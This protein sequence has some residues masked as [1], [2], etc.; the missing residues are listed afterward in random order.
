[1]ANTSSIASSCA[2]LRTHLNAPGFA[3]SKFLAQ[4]FSA[5]CRADQLTILALV[6]S[7]AMAE[8]SRKAV[9]AGRANRNIVARKGA[10]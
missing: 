10:K 9:A 6:H 2:A 5:M 7:R 4:H 8:G 1:M 3:E